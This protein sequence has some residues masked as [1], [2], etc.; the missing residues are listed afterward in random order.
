LMMEKTGAGP[1]KLEYFLREKI[2]FQ[3]ITGGIIKATIDKQNNLT[4]DKV[5]ILYELNEGW[6][7]KFILGVVSSDYINKWIK[8]SFGNLLEIK[9]NNLQQLPI[10]KATTEQ[11]TQIAGL[12]DEIMSLKMEVS[13]KVRKFLK[14]LEVEIKNTPSAKAATPFGKG[15][16]KPNKK[17][18]EFWKLDFGEFITETEKQKIKLTLSQK[19]EWQDYFEAKK[20]AVL[21]LEKEV[22]RVDSEIEKLIRNLY[23]F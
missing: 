12:V 19:S 21:E 10:P 22:E 14:L 2:L 6:N 17:L 18:M 11:Q 5:H 20:K 9:I 8:S 13:E 16:F 1:R 7:L 23:K 15:E 3:S 4:N